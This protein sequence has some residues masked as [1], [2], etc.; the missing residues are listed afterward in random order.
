[1]ISEERRGEERRGEACFVLYISTFDSVGVSLHNLLLF[2][3]DSSVPLHFMLHFLVA[4]YVVSAFPG[5][6][7]NWLHTGNFIYNIIVSNCLRIPNFRQV[8]C[9]MSDI[10]KV[11]H[12]WSWAQTASAQHA[13][14]KFKH[15]A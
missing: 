15:W 9:N 10:G 7:P 11:G 13:S 8:I 1:M 6:Q 12:S 14:G 2:L 4:F 5:A 3:F